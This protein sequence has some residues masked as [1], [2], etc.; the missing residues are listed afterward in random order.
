VA[1]SSTPATK[2]CRR[3]PRR[4]KSHLAGV[5]PRYTYCGFA[6]AGTFTHSVCR[7]SEEKFPKGRTFRRFHA[8][9]W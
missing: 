5:L 2:T 1:F 6:L 8:L 7:N 3:G 9:Y 4:G